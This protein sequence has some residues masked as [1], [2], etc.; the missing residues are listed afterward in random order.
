MELTPDL[1]QRADHAPIRYRGAN[2][3]TTSNALQAQLTHQ[4]LHRASRN[5]N[6]LT[7]E[8][9][10]DFHYAIALHIVI[11]DSLDFIAQQLVLLGTG[12][13]QFGLSGFDLTGR[14]D[15][16]YPTDRLR[17]GHGTRQRRRSG[18][19][20]APG[21]RPVGLRL[22]KK[23]TGQA[24]NLICLTQLTI[25]AFQSLDAFSFLGRLTRA[26][27]NISLVFAYPAM[28]RLGDTANLGRNG[29]DGCPF[30]GVVLQVLQN[31]AHSTFTDFRGI[32]IGFLH[33]SFSQ[34]LR[35][36]RNPV[37]FSQYSVAI[38]IAVGFEGNTQNR[39]DD[40]RAK[41]Y[42][43]TEWTHFGHR[44]FSADFYQFGAGVTGSVLVE[45]RK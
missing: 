32:A 38:C 27:A 43:A 35:P 21:C 9:L 30:G 26:V 15:L 4:P 24:Q 6:A 33:A 5:I 37:R 17:S 23:S 22:G 41:K 1:I 7:L 12:A 36:P 19:V 42:A 18:F 25:L 29:F 28:Q 44:A 10:P 8:L 16:D 45:R 2:H 3:M 11:P 31:H 39:Q 13:L 14:S 40:D 34:E 20:A